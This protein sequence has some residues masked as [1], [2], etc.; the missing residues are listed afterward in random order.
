MEGTEARR[1]VGAKPP[2]PYKDDFLGAAHEWIDRYMR[3]LAGSDQHSAM[4][5]VKRLAFGEWV[6]STYLPACDQVME[7]TT[8]L[9]ALSICMLAKARAANAYTTAVAD[10]RHRA[11]GGYP[12][13]G[14]TAAP[15][16][17]RAKHQFR[18]AVA[19]ATRRPC[20]LW[21]YMLHTVCTLYDVAIHEDAANGPSHLHSFLAVTYEMLTDETSLAL[22]GSEP[23]GCRGQRNQA[24]NMIDE[25]LLLGKA[26][27][28]KAGHDSLHSA[29]DKVEDN[30]GL[31]DAE[32]D[33]TE[34][35]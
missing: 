5:P 15:D 19:S 22:A 6:L 1:L 28:D 23:G 13:G 8:D 12:G 31:A 20:A 21:A 33:E 24:A 9:S 3:R 2:R 7:A 14:E 18:H 32:C 16:M 35:D 10:Y 34:S 4:S 11:H 27:G 17:H 30:L 29:L 26:Q 25:L